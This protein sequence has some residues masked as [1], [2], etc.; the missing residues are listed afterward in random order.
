MNASEGTLD[1]RNLTIGITVSKFNGPVTEKLL[2]SAIQCLVKHK[3]PSGA[4]HVVRVPG[5]FELPYAAQKLAESERYD[6]ILCL[7]AVIQGETPHFD[8][9]CQETTRGIGRVMSRFSLPVIFGVLTTDTLEQAKERS[10][11]RASNK[12]WEAAL[13]ALEMATI[14]FD[15]LVPWE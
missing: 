11:D 13:A 12:G 7:G 14:P 2:D 5:A 9:I 8:Y 15:E 10:G 3:V 1:G 6:A 4:I